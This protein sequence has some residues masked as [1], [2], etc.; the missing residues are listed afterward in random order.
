MANIT[1]KRTIFFVTSPRTPFKMRDEINLLISNFE[2]R[3]WNKETQTEYARKLSQSDFFEGEIEKNLDFAARDRINR[4]PKAL[5]FVNL[6]PKISLTDAGKQFLF[7]KRPE[8]VFLRQLLKFQLPS[9]YHTDKNNDFNIK[10]YLELLRLIVDLGGLTKDEIAIFAMQLTNINDY[11]KTVKKILSFRNRVENIDRRQTSYRRT[12]REIYREELTELYKTEISAG[13]I[14]TRQ[15]EDNSL[16]NFI[17][18]KSSNF[19]DYADASIRYL[20]ATQLLSFEYKTNRLLPSKYK[21]NDIDFILSRVERS[22]TSFSNEEE[23]KNYLFDSS[24]PHLLSDDIKGLIAELSNLSL[25]AEQL[26]EIKSLPLE[27]AKDKRDEILQKTQEENVGQQVRNLQA[28]TEYEDI[29]KTYEDIAQG[30]IV[31]PSLIFE[32]NTW[33]AFTMLNDG[34]IEG[35]FKFD[36]QG[37]PLFNAPGNKP[38]IECEYTGYNIIVEVTLSSGQKQYEMEGEPVAR[39]LGLHQKE[40]GAETYCIFITQQL[41]QATLAHFY[42]LHKIDI[43]FYGGKAKIIPIEVKDFQKLLHTAYQSINKPASKDIY[44][45]VNQATKLA[46]TTRNELEWYQNIT[47]LADSWF[48]P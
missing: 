25:S 45:F 44:E 13:S 35:N 23:F 41:S 26:E 14:E 22:A 40:K 20:R 24:L 9:P 16:E 36:L 6:H 47:N 11:D 38:D 10:P 34:K 21:L 28:Y 31:D 1:N 27:R 46:G 42:S 3:E 4:S 30:S 7:S 37:M 5:G 48:R 8:E 18:T 19:R 29:T 39:H 17:E 2:G 15:S 33:R 32:W 43:A 12:I